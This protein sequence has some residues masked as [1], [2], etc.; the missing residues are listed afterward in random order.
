MG[1]GVEVGFHAE[2]GSIVGQRG[3][4]LR[5]NLVDMLA[6]EQR[7]AVEKATVIVHRRWGGNVMH[8]A[9]FVIVGAV[10][11]GDMDKTRALIYSN[12]V[13]RQKRHVEGIVVARQR[14]AC[15]RAGERMAGENVLALEVQFC[16]LSH[17]AL[18]RRGQHDAIAGLS[19]G[20]VLRLHYLVDGVFHI[21]T[22]G[23]GP[24]AGHS[25]RRRRPDHN[26]GT[27]DRGHANLGHGKAHEDCRR[28]DIVI[29]DLGLGQRGFL[30]RRPH[31]R[32]S[33]LVQP[34]IKQKLTEF[35][36]DLRLGLVRH[37][38][39]A[40]PPVGEYAEANELLHL[41]AN[42]LLGIGATFAAELLD[43][44]LVLA[45]AL[46]A[47]VLLDLPLD[48]QAMT[49]PAWDVVGI[50]AAHLARAIDH[51]L[52]NLVKRCP[53]VYRPVRIGRAIMQDELLASARAFPQLGPEF[54]ALPA[55]Q[56]IGLTL[57]QAG[58]HGKVGARQKQGAFVVPGHGILTD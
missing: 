58:F 41:G 10:A 44:Y 17:R 7:H 47:V 28:S 20:T 39:V 8:S 25:P 42:P 49:V 36:H 56:Y 23:N 37:S 48:G 12:E 50:E 11:G 57:G 43:R 46:F 35:A 30:D 52:E 15:P 55:C 1:I 6:G 27:G 51:V 32:L 53:H 9:K 4:D 22:I 54:D 38:E 2:Q 24:V 34:T 13:S 3:D 31:Y 5:I 26:I 29:L 21:F 18:Q 19:L 45:L 16:L 40:A 14:M 33:A